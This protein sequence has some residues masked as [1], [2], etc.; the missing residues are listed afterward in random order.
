MNSFDMYF[1][2]RLAV[3]AGRA[4]EHIKE[5]VYFS[6]GAY[7]WDIGGNPK[8]VEREDLEEIYRRC[9]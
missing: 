1:P 2:V 3:G 4:A 9:L 8:K 6:L 5:A 7:Q